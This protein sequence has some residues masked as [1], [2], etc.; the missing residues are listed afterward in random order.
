[1][2][3]FEHLAIAVLKAIEQDFDLLEDV[4]LGLRGIHPL[5]QLVKELLLVQLSVFFS[6]Q[7]GMHLS[8]S[9]GVRAC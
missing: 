3:L 5:R 9:T 2:Q 7:I 8:H 1:M 4:L 6:P